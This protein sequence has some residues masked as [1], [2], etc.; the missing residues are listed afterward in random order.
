MFPSNYLVSWGFL[1]PYYETKSFK[2]TQEFCLRENF[3]EHVSRILCAG[4]EE[5]FNLFVF[6]AL[7]DKMISDINVLSLMLLDWILSNEYGALIVSANGE[8][9]YWYL[10]LRQKCFNPNTLS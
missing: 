10:Q 5:Q 1:L 4:Y 7:S 3:G 8:V 2:T 9:F 6:N